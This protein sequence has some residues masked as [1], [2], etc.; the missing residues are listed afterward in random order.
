MAI[1]RAFRKNYSETTSRDETQRRLV[2]LSPQSPLHHRHS[3]D[4]H[5]C[6]RGKRED[7]ITDNSTPFAPQE[8][9]PISTLFLSLHQSSTV[10]FERHPLGRQAL[11]N[12]SFIIKAP[13]SLTCSSSHEQPA[14]WKRIDTSI[15]SST[16]RPREYWHARRSFIVA[17]HIKARKSSSS[18]GTEAELRA[19][20][21]LSLSFMLIVMLQAAGKATSSSGTSTPANQQPGSS[22]TTPTSAV[23]PQQPSTPISNPL[24]NVSINVSYPNGTAKPVA[25]PTGPSA[26]NGSR[27]H[28]RASS[29][30]TPYRAAPPQG[31][32]SSKPSLSG[33]PAYYSAQSPRIPAINNGGRNSPFVDYHDEVRLPANYLTL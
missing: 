25:P 30:T 18:T 24:S 7:S 23:P 6:H 3:F 15:L 12:G 17:P 14:D 31:P 19:G 26:L 32:H 16:E 20:M 4:R 33:Q 1:C 27:N 29:A 11:P 22:A 5:L 21:S 28:S 13:A 10:P 2:S 8:Q 9:Q